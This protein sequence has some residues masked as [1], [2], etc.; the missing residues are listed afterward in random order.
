MDYI[1]Q[2]CYGLLFWG[3]DI[4]MTYADKEYSIVVTLLTMVLTGEQNQ[5]VLIKSK[6]PASA[7]IVL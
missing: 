1:V 3:G 6:I 4:N 2:N 7:F 5:L